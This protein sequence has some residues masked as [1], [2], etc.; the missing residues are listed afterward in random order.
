LPIFSATEVPNELIDHQLIKTAN[1]FYDLLVARKVTSF[2]IAEPGTGYRFSN[3]ARAYMQALVRCCIS[4]MDSGY[5]EFHAGRLLT[6]YSS[7]R[8]VMETIAVMHD[9]VETL[10]PLVNA[11][12]YRE[13]GELIGSRALATR[14]PSFAEKTDPVY[15]VQILKQIDKLDK[16]NPGYRE[17]YDHMSDVVHPNALGAVVYFCSFEEGDVV[18][19]EGIRDDSRAIISLILA[20]VK[21]GFAELACEKLV[22]Y[23]SH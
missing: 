1:L 4:F 12:Q 5:A 19:G 8:S 23:W 22:H 14:V 6:V 17:A 7:A 10:A 13:A 18:F 20:G 9:F 16:R 21:L 2:T 15:A 11:A 3:L